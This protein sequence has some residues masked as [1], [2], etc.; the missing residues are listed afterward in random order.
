MLRTTL[1]AFSLDRGVPERPEGTPWQ[2]TIVNPQ[3]LHK[4]G[5]K[6][7]WE[8]VLEGLDGLLRGRGAQGFEVGSALVLVKPVL[9]AGP[10]LYDI[11]HSAHLMS[12]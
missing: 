11:A 9:D 8:G 1:H 12:D 6:R 4:V 3:P 5:M 7:I 2:S 10:S